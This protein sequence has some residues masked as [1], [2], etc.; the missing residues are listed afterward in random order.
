MITNL[1]SITYL[2][3]INYIFLNE[4]SNLVSSERL[5]TMNP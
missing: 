3:Q 2:L 5:W 4:L 1:K